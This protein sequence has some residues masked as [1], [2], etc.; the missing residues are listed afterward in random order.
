[1]PPGS[2]SLRLRLV[3]IGPQSGAAAP[4][5]VA[6]LSAA[7]ASRLGPRHS[8]LG[9]SS[10][11]P[12]DVQGHWRPMIASQGSAS[13]PIPLLDPNLRAGWEPETRSSDSIL[14]AFLTNWSDLTAR[15]V[16]LHGG[17]ALRRDDLVA[18]DL[19]RP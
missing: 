4:G 7:G 6:A 9:T 10:L 5:L 16:E 3:S 2:V 17:Q 11:L 8:A 19:G 1:M 14:R 15:E 13:M 12:Y 18:Y